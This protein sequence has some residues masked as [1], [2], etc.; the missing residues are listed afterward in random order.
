MAK[1]EWFRKE[2]W[3]LEDESD[4]FAHLKRAR[5]S[6]N[7]A[8]YLNIQAV[9][10]N[11]M[12]DLNLAAAAITLAQK[13][14]DDF[15]EERSQT[16]HSYCIIGESYEQLGKIEDAVSAYL[17][18]IET[19]RKF[20]NFL[21]NA[22]TKFAMLVVRHKL[23]EQ[24]ASAAEILNEYKRFN[25]FP[26]ELF[27]HW[28][29]LAII[30][31]QSGYENDAKLFAGLA[32]DAAHQLHSGFAHHPDLGLVADR[33]SD[34][35]KQLEEIA[36]RP[37]NI[38]LN[39][40]AAKDIALD[41]REREKDPDDDTKCRMA[42]MAVG[43]NVNSIHDM[44]NSRADY[45]A[46]I[47]VLIQLLR[48]VET[49]NIKEEVVRALGVKS[50]KRIAEIPLIEEFLSIPKTDEFHHVKWV[51]G[52]TLY[53]LG[54]IDLYFDKIAEIVKDTSH[55]TTRRMM[56]MLLGK[57]KK[58][59]EEAG[60]IALELIEQKDVQGHAIRALGNLRSACA[61]EAIENFL[62][63]ENE[64]HK[65]EARTALKKIQEYPVKENG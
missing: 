2:S 55:G 1:Q 33:S 31:D 35:Y 7:K 39:T 44:V 61:T 40:Q 60:K 65:R 63:S 53:S 23:I 64:W 10:L 52:N 38:P 42:L 57:S 8:Q 27:Q 47:P 5:T 54:T 6:Y 32:L 46:A 22:P 37:A 14:I 17:K 24:Y 50:A 34:F 25:Y 19:Q 58:N 28:G 9:T 16:A 41:M 15:P 51:I 56:V 18:C 48:L 26:F 20:P 43:I 29:C 21:T 36:K 11:S 4:F 59:K 62:S 13:C 49:P 12:K 3:S 30:A 45:P